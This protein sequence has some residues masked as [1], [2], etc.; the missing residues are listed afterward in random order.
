VFGDTRRVDNPTIQRRRLGNALRRA[1]EAAGRTQD[2]AA[3][4]L[5]AAS[6]KVS[7]LELGQS[8]VRL[9][10]L[11]ILLDYYAV[12]PPEAASM[13]DL[14]RAGRQR[15]RWSGYRNVV[16]QW[17]RQYMDLELDATS[18]RWYQTEL[19]PGLLQTESYIRA[20]HRRP[21]DQPSDE[22]VERRVKVRLERQ[23]ILHRQSPPEVGFILSES[24]L[25]RRIGDPETMQEQL[26][27]LAD[28][29]DRPNVDLQVY[30]FAAE[31]FVTSV[32]G[33]IMLGFD[34]MSASVVYL[35]DFSDA[36]Y[37]D[38]PEVLRSY[39]RLWERLSA[40]ALGPAESR[41]FILR[42]ADEVK[43]EHE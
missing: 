37:L 14:A 8:G 34:G 42:V 2:E 25:R 29:C 36:A 1:R 40:A 3:M 35:E 30:P 41:K 4:V 10:D 16:P 12:A 23:A 38:R 17:F 9:T 7:R 22:E 31:S 18:V 5:D 28:F 15:G 39:G 13:R 11:N 27:H 20:M 24:A 32:F 21:E 26:H 19:V 6:S 43:R 33:F